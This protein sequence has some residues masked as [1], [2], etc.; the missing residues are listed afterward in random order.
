MKGRGIKSFKYAMSE[1]QTPLP[2]GATMGRERLRENRRGG[3]E[4]RD[5]RNLQT[6]SYARCCVCCGLREYV[7]KCEYAQWLQKILID[8]NT[9]SETWQ[10][11]DE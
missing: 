3:Q 7:G 2:A 10:G 4:M 11:S 5:C 8:Q 9:R 6:S 1:Y